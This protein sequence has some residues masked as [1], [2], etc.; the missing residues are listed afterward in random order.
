MPYRALVIGCG[1]IG[2][3]YDLHDDRIATHAKAFHLSKDCSLTVADV[4]SDRA[5]EIATAYGVPF[6][7]DLSDIA[8]RQFDIVSLCVPTHL[9]YEFLSRTVRLGVPLVICEKPVV[10]SLEEIQMLKNLVKPETKILVNYMRRFLPAFSLLKN[11]LESLRKVGPVRQIVVRYQRGFLNNGS[12]GW[13][14]LR[15]LLDSPLTLSQALVVGYDFDVFEDDPTATAFVETLGYAIS[16]IGL[17]R[18][19]YDMFEIDLYAANR[20]IQIKNGGDR[21][22]YFSS[23]DGSSRALQE[24]TELAQTDAMKDYMK[25]VVDNAIDCLEGRTETNFLSALEVNEQ[26]LNL[27]STM[28]RD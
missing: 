9:H 15:F 18:V 16:F 22:L 10:A 25:P 8:L 19:G 26:F 13:D 6:L 28:K 3:G 24:E 27:I 23:G 17:P 21:I 5:R 20:I 7:I 4:D 12:H 11:R 1:K 14:L 2:A